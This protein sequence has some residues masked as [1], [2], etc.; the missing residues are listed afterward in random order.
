MKN[1]SPPDPN[2]GDWKPLYRAGILETNTT[3]IPKLVPEAKGLP[4]AMSQCV[5][6]ETHAPRT[7]KLKTCFSTLD[8]ARGR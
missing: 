1:A 3:S 4:L 8:T 6:D 5:A 2:H 7:K